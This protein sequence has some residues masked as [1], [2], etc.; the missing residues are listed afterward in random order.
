MN[1]RQQVRMTAW[2]AC[3][4]E[5]PALFDG[6]VLVHFANGSIE[7]VHV[8]DYFK[9]IRNGVDENG[10][11]KWSRWYLHSDPAVTHWAHLI[12]PPHSF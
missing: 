1:S 5:L 7:T 2:N 11:P 10:E 6:S 8:E 3:E 12:E 9:E 4:D